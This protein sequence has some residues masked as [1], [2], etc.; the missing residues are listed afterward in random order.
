[1]SETKEQGGSLRPPLFDGDRNK[2]SNWKTKACAY[3]TWKRCHEATL[4][5]HAAKM[6]EKHDTPLDTSVDAEKKQDTARSQNSM[7][8]AIYTLSFTSNQLVNMIYES[9]NENY[10][11]GRA[12]EVAKALD[13]K[14]EPKDMM[15]I[16]ERKNDLDKIKM[17]IREHPSILFEQL[18]GIKNKYKNAS[19]KMTDQEMQAYVIE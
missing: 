7:A 3:M 16:V 2:Y 15:T 4:A 14:Y 8:V 9:S 19:G 11:G 1:M 6:P 13:R 5:S 18:C 12:W 17:S 10:P